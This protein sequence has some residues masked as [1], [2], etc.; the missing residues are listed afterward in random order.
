M[1]YM[2]L[3][4]AALPMFAALFQRPEQIAASTRTGF[5]ASSFHTL[6]SIEAS[7]LGSIEASMKGPFKG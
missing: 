3:A 1:A 6:G 5:S 4:G 7:T 2:T